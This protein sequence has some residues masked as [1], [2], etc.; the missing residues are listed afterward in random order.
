MAKIHEL[1]LK[2]LPHTPYSPDLA[3]SDY[4]LLPN[5]KICLGGQRFANNEKMESAVNGY[6]EQLDGS[7][8]KQGIEAMKH[9]W[10]LEGDYV[11]K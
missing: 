5:L 9:R 10:E 11:E 7:H 4:F 2:L 3:L 8:N 1:K 6:F